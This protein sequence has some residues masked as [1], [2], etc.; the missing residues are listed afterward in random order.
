MNYNVNVPA[1]GSYTFSFRVATPLPGG[2]LR[3]KNTAGA[4]LADVKVPNTGNYEIWTTATATV[5][6]PAGNQTLQILNEGPTGWNIN[7]MDIEKSKTAQAAIATTQ[8]NT[9]QVFDAA[10]AT[11]STQQTDTAQ[12]TAPASPTDSTA[13]GQTASKTPKDS[14]SQPGSK[15]PT[16]T[17]QQSV[18]DTTRQA[19]AA[20]PDSKLSEPT[21]ST[22]T[23]FPNPAHDNFTL[24]I[25]NVYTGKMIIQVISQSGQL[26]KTY[27]FMKESSG[28]TNTVNIAE[29]TAGMYFIRIRVGTWTETKKLLK[30]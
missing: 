7:W 29:L 3:L 27:E 8:T 24:N 21:T 4:A 20:V 14:T 15:S 11:D 9:A 1:A 18:S 22:S 13:T 17:A 25:N 12:Q 28:S 2:I 16:D 23:L 30:L 10:P 26:I 19:D 6:L 5:T